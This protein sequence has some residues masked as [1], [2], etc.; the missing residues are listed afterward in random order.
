MYEPVDEDEEMEESFDDMHH[1]RGSLEITAVASTPM[2]QAQSSEG[3][4]ARLEGGTE[5]LLRPKRRLRPLSKMPGRAALGLAPSLQSATRAMSSRWMMDENERCAER[6]PAA[7]STEYH[8][9]PEGPAD[10]DDDDDVD[11]DDP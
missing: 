2:P 8:A 1:W 9:R 3:N 5:V 6:E 4:I 11:D 7:Q 10:D